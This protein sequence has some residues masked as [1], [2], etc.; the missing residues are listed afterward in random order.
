[1]GLFDRFKQPKGADAIQTNVV[2]LILSSA[3]QTTQ[4]TIEELE[5]NHGLKPL[6]EPA[7]VET[8]QTYIFF[9]YHWIARVAHARL[10]DNERVKVMGGLHDKLLL[11]YV[12][13]ATIAVA[14]PFERE[15]FRKLL[16][17]K[18]GAFHK[19][20]SNYGLPVEGSENSSGTLL[21]EVGKHIAVAVGRPKDPFIGAVGALHASVGANVMNKVIKLEDLVS[22]NF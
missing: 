7:V 10:N 8:L 21:Y 6:S 19:E 9:N 11:A 16:N 5:A 12:E 14:T 13:T 22:G 17:A 4:K 15:Q 3:S 18:L 20:F 1:V 2:A